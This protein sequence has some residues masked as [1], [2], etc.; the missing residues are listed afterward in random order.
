MELK[1]QTGEDSYKT[2]PLGAV[3]YGS[4]LFGQNL[5]VPMRSFLAQYFPMFV[6]N[7]ARTLYIN[8]GKKLVFSVNKSGTFTKYQANLKHKW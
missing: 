5:S 6:M 8:S 7:Q 4:A 1:W 2:A 3:R